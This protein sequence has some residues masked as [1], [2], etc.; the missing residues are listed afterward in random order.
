MT[1]DC[2]VSVI[3]NDKTV[4]KSH[5][6]YTKFVTEWFDW[7]WAISII[8]VREFILPLTLR[9][10]GFYIFYIFIIV[11]VILTQVFFGWMKFINPMTWTVFWLAIF[12]VAVEPTMNIFVALL[13]NK[14]V[15][16]KAID[17]N[18]ENVYERNKDI[19]VII[20]CNKSADVI[21]NTLVHVILHVKQEQVFIIHNG[22]SKDPVDNTKEIAL[23]SFPNV[24]YVWSSIGNKNIAQYIGMK[25]AKD[26]KYC[27]VIDDDVI[28]PENFDMGVELLNDKTKGV[29][30]PLGAIASEGRNPSWLTKSQDIE[31]KL[32]GTCKQFQ[33]DT[34]SVLYPHGAIALWEIEAFERLLYEQHDCIFYAEDVKC[35]IGASRLGY[36]LRMHSAS[37]I[38]TEVPMTIFGTFPNYYTQ[39][40]RYWDMGEHIYFTLFLGNLFKVWWKGDN[41]IK[42]IYGNF[43]RKVFE[44]YGIY[45]MSMDIVKPIVIG[46]G[47]LYVRFWVTLAIAMVLNFFSLIL[48][49]Y[50]ALRGRTDVNINIYDLFV[51][52]FFYRPLIMVTRLFGALRA[53]LIYHPNMGHKP[54][55]KDYEDNV[56]LRSKYDPVWLRP[57]VSDGTYNDDEYR[58]AVPVSC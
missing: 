31:Y 39:R 25:L 44:L 33:S 3:A 30:Y 14:T 32:A 57:G 20:P 5:V 49:R 58:N 17:L 36:E 12:M 23:A 50:Y 46:I 48:W 18:L 29:A 7:K 37:F 47:F 11:I 1:D 4:S 27:L 6:I 26:Y 43:I 10:I 55:I 2:V 38:N 40:I 21:V 24:H 22:S 19:V 34:S 35:G 9:K 51:N 13:T 56:E 8:D 54:R 15:Q 28:L 16:N 42:T 53:Y 41:W 45:T 52:N